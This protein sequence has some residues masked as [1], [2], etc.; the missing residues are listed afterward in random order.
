MTKPDPF[1]VD[2]ENPEWTPEMFA[3][4]RP[5]RAVLGNATVDALVKRQRGRPKSENPK[6]AV[7]LRL[8]AAILEAFK[9]RGPGWQTRINDA[10]LSTLTAEEINMHQGGRP[11]AHRADK[12]PAA[13]KVG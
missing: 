12:A 13:R 5:A 2:D 7:K 9:G 11:A 10:L 4:A 1:K 3:K 8:D 6:V